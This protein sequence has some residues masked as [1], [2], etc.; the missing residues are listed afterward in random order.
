MQRLAHGQPG[1]DELA[2]ALVV[3]ERHHDLVVGARDAAE[4]VDEVHVP[5]GAAELPVGRHAQ[6][7]VL[8]QGDDL[9]DRVVL[10]LAQPVG[11][12]APFREVMSGLHQRPR[13][14]QATDMLGPERRLDASVHGRGT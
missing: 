11:V 7:D 8:L 10:H 5:R 13:A 6:A 3:A 4:L 9:A 14:Q 1:G 2:G 12:D